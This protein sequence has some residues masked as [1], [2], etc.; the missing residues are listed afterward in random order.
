MI[1]NWDKAAK[2]I[3]E[4]GCKIAYAGLAEDYR[5]TMG[6]IFDNGTPVDSAAY[7]YSYWATP[8]LELDGEKEPCFLTDEEDTTDWN[9]HTMWPQSALEIIKSYLPN[10]GDVRVDEYEI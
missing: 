7:L 4:S 5:G 2:R 10:V 9:E 3:A 6:L 8:I 1:F